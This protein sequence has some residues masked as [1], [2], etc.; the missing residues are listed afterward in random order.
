MPVVQRFNGRHIVAEYVPP[1]VETRSDALAAEVDR[2]S[3][4]LE[5]VIRTE[6]T[7]RMASRCL[8]LDPAPRLRWLSADTKNLR[9][10]TFGAA[11]GEIWVRVADIADAEETALHE[12]RHVHQMRRYV[13]DGKELS[14]EGDELDAEDF[15]KTWSPWAPGSPYAPTAATTPAA[16]QAAAR[17]LWEQRYAPIQEAGRQYV[18]ERQQRCQM[19]RHNRHGWW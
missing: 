1:I 5:L 13:D 11:L 10:V 15:A 3:V 2:G 14:H 17:R 8:G 4:D 18:A 12:V 9:G 16:D 7:V 6:R 19:H